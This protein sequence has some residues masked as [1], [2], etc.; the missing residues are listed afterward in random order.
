MSFFVEVF[1]VI[2]RVLTVGSGR[3]NGLS[4][5]ILDDLDEGVTVEALVCNNDFWCFVFEQRLG[6]RNVVS[7]S[8]CHHEV[9]GVA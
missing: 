9:R 1:I 7:L 8:A 5:D 3:Y 2:P 6:L 4:T